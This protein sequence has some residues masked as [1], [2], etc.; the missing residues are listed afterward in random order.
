MDCVGTHVQQK[1]MQWGLSHIRTATVLMLSPLTLWIHHNVLL[2][3]QDTQVNSVLEMEHMVTL[4]FLIQSLLLVQMIHL[5]SNR[6]VL[7]LRRHHWF[8]THKLNQLK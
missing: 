1:A 2:A 6:V 4:K 7:R 8:R 5:L 3:V